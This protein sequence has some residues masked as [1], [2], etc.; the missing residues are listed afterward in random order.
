M[1]KKLREL[2]LGPKVRAMVA[3]SSK[4]RKISDMAATLSAQMRAVITRQAI[5]CHIASMVKDGTARM[6]GR[7]EVERIK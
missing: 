6:V 2:G 4:P 5:G 3:R 1:A 7:G